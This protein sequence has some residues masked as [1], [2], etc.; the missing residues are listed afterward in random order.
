[1]TVMGLKTKPTEVLPTAPAN[2][3][4]PEESFTIADLEPASLLT[5]PD[6]DDILFPDTGTVM[7]KYGTAERRFRMAERV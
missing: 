1:M 3:F 7:E 2:R 6:G 4:P 5:C